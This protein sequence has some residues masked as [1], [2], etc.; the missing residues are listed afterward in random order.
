MNMTTVGLEDFDDEDLNM[1]SVKGW[2]LPPAG[3]YECELSLSV[4][5]VNDENKVEWKY[6]IVDSDDDETQV[7]NT[8]N[9]LMGIKP[10]TNK[11]T[12]K[13]TDPRVFFKKKA[14]SLSKALDVPN[15][16]KA[17]VEAAQNVRVSCYLD[18]RVVKTKDGETAY[19][20][21]RD[22]GFQVL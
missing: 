18:H 9:E 20:V 5:Q 3:T 12:G 8:F 11:D 13:V 7:G 19:A 14:T 4:K 16:I 17:L 2:E 1:D 21:V 22:V 6:K 15:N 10:I